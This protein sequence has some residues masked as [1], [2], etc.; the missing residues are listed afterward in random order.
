MNAAAVVA[1]A[2]G[3]QD[4]FI[5]GLN[6]QLN[7]VRSISLQIVQDVPVNVIRTGGKMDLV[8]Q[9]SL[10]V[11]LGD[12]QIGGLLLHGD[13]GKAAAEKGDFNGFHARTVRQSGKPGFN[14]VSDFIA[15]HV[16]LPGC[17]GFLI[18]EHTVIGAALVG[19][20]NRDDSVFFHI[21]IIGFPCP[22]LFPFLECNIRPA[23]C[24][25]GD[26]IKTKSSVIFRR[27]SQA[28]A[29]SGF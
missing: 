17:D 28:G 19:D 15:G 12:F 22:F 23:A 14:G 9:S 3:F 5:K 29:R 26:S 6:S 2:R 18:A 21:K 13:A 27:I 10:F 8:D 4:L 1:A 24:H 7:G 11:I 20:E 16:R 25:G